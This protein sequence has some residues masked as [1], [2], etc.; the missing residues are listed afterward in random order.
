MR[1]TPLRRM[2]VI[3]ETPAWIAEYCNRVLDQELTV[4]GGKSH[5]GPVSAT[6]E[7]RLNDRKKFKVFQSLKGRT[8]SRSVVGTRWWQEGCGCLLGGERLA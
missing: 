7:G 1:L 8:P 5:G 2:G 4:E 6:K 3:A